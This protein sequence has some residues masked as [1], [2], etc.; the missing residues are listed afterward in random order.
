MSIIIRISKIL[1]GMLSTPK[2][3]RK[4]K[5]TI[6]YFNFVY[7]TLRSLCVSVSA[8]VDPCIYG[9]TDLAQGYKPRVHVM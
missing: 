5:K 4:K 1:R 8:E 7:I 6:K 9:A 2:I 3:I